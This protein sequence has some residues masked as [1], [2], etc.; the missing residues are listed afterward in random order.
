MNMNISAI[1][2]KWE[3]VNTTNNEKADEY[4]FVC[5]EALITTNTSSVTNLGVTFSIGEEDNT[6]SSYGY[7]II[8]AVTLKICKR[9]HFQ[10]LC[11]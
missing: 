11:K 9:R 2:T 1:S 3:N 7:A 10:S 8:S 5:Y 4:G 6:K